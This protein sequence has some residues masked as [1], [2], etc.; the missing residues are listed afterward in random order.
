MQVVFVFMMSVGNFV[1]FSI[2]KIYDVPVDHMFELMLGICG[3]NVVV[4]G[5]LFLVAKEK[6]LTRAPGAKKMSVCDP[7]TSVVDA[8]KGSPS[9]LYHLAAVQCLVWVGNTAWNLYAGQWMSD[10]VFEGD[11]NAPQGSPGHEKYAQ[12][13]TA[14]N[15]AG[16]AKSVL[17]LVSALAIIAILVNN[18]VRPRTV[19]A[20]CIFI[21]AIVSV[22]AATVVGHNAS[23]AIVCMA[24]SIMPETG[25]FAIPFGLVATLNKRA[26][27][28][29]KAVSTALQMSLLNCC[30]TV[31]QQICTLA[32][33][34]IES[35][36]SLEASLP[37]VF[38]LSAAAQTLAGFGAMRLDDGDPDADNSGSE[39]E[40]GDESDM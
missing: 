11:L 23:F 18:W 10:S 26:E 38:A 29:G 9:L 37:W 1:A 5:I 19:Y 39:E 4:V 32:L 40:S 12:G 17:Q 15:N 2:M 16:Q 31:G 27:K 36:M 6:P 35:Q 28:E 20:P 22:L 33:A 24:F 25:S 14:F 21:G 3:L 13:Q 7:I 8:V 30:V 34:G